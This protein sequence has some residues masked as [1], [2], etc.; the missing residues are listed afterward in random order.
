MRT[1]VRF[2]ALL[3][4]VLCGCTERALSVGDDSA[5][6]DVGVTQHDASTVDAS[7]G[8]CKPGE[9]PVLLADDVDPFTS[10]IAI[11]G[12]AILYGDNGGRF[13][14][15][16]RSGGSKS[17]FSN[18][19]GTVWTLLPDRIDYVFR[20]NDCQKIG[21]SALRELDRA[22]GAVSILVPQ[23]VDAPSAI[24]ADGQDVV[25]LAAAPG[26]MDNGIRLH[27]YKRASK[28]WGVFRSLIG[29]GQGLA[30]VDRKLTFIDDTKI[31]QKSL[32]NEQTPESEL[33]LP[34]DGNGAFGFVQSGNT[35]ITVTSSGLLWEIAVGGSTKSLTFERVPPGNIA[36]DDRD[37]V[38]TGWN[39]DARIL[40]VPRASGNVRVL[41]QGE[42]DSR[43]LA[44]DDSCVYYTTG[45]GSP[46]N[47]AQHL[48]RAPR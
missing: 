1:R 46:A 9:Q 26:I 41:A 39:S 20:P 4:L 25:V 8:L 11:D 21:C 27:R 3:V 35:V 42:S 36:F 40:T 15:V 47:E 43:A 7:M 22:T 44:L 28:T 6:R 13:V 37:V 2:S 48:Y 14:R 33:T 38:T 32:L 16:P 29:P 23:G 45:K 31:L 34:P 10:T 19:A 17:T 18:E 24:A 30:V 12:D 5:V